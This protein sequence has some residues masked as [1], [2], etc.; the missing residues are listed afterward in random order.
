M[1]VTWKGHRTKFLGEM[2]F[3]KTNKQTQTKSGKISRTEWC[4][5][6]GDELEVTGVLGSIQDMI[7]RFYSFPSSTC[8]FSY[9]LIIF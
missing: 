2:L 5:D 9:I 3:D 8:F 6:T 7:V 4:K 1:I